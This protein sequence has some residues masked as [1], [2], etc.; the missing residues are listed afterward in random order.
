[1]CLQ[2]DHETSENEWLS[3]DWFVFA[4][5]NGRQFVEGCNGCSIELGKYE[6][7]IWNNREYIRDYLKIRGDQEKAWSDQEQLLN[8]I[9]GI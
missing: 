8:T 6:Q 3:E 4:E 2:I 9:A 1:M 5:I 7:F